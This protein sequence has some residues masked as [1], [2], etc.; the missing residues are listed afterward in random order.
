MRATSDQPGPAAPEDRGGLRGRRARRRVAGRER[1]IG[2]RDRLAGAAVADHAV[3]AA[4]GLARHEAPVHAVARHQ[5]G[6]GAALGHPAL[7]EHQDAIGADDAGEPVG[8][9]E[10]GA[11]AHQPVQRVLDRGLALRVHRG[12]RFVQDQDGRV[13]EQ[14]AGDRDALALAA[15]EPHPAL[16]HHRLVALGQGHD[17][18]VHVGVARGRLELGLA[19]V[20]AR[21][22]GGSPRWCRGRDRCPGSP[23]RSGAAG[24]AARGRAGRAR[25]W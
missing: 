24:P 25:R 16:A 19:R 1:V 15:R 9:D 6:V 7:V 4:R 12:E 13:A 23:P 14:R 18:V 20:G 11:P 3:G 10:R 8:E 5:G 17:G 22:C 2:F 21:P